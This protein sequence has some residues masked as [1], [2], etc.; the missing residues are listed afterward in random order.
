MNV[1]VSYALE[2]HL[3]ADEFVDILHR[4]TLAQRRPVNERAR[5]EKMLAH[6][7]II[8]TA[9]TEDGRLVGVSRCISDFSFCC[10]C[11]DLAVD[12]AFQRRG[13]GAR[14]IKDSAAAAGPYAHFL[15]L[16]APSVERFYDGLSFMRRH[17]ACFEIPDWK[18]F[19]EDP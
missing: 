12:V 10:Y 17:S 5:I 9:R 6:A 4:S 8:V 13:I 18:R 2:P 1:A 11:S 3:C 14:L 19:E 7:D 15:L 16:S